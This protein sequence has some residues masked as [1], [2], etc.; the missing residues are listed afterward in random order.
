[1]NVHGIHP[2][3]DIT[4]TY[5]VTY[6]Q[7]EELRTHMQNDNVIIDFG[8]VTTSGKFG[9]ISSFEKFFTASITISL[10]S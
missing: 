4:R 5:N 10:I 8:L 1:M 6:F 7:S 3:I 2:S 9:L